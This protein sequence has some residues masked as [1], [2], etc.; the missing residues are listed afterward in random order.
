[1]RRIRSLSKDDFR[2]VFSDNVSSKDKDM[3]VLALR[4]T[5]CQ[6]RLGL[7]VSKKTAKRAVDRN[8]L[9]R[10]IRESVRM[11]QRLL[12]CLD[13]VVISRKGLA[14]RSNREIFMA[15]DRHW[16]KLNQKFN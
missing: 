16:H 8:R 3:I 2:R 13:I 4:N 5:L 7:A 6:P 14:R 12:S 1:M 9:K 10:V 11:N 15:L